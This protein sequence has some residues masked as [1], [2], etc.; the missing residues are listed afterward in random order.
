MWHRSFRAFLFSLGRKA[1]DPWAA[2][3]DEIRMSS[4]TLPLPNPRLLRR[5]DL[6]HRRRS[7]EMQGAGAVERADRIAIGGEGGLQKSGSLAFQGDQFLPALG[8]PQLE[9]VL[10]TGSGCQ[11]F[12]V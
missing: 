4:R 6:G 10:T 8:V 7:P 5:V 11:A 2:G 9:G 1:K 3:L 12:A